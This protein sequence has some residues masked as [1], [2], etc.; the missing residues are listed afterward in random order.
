MEKSDIILEM[1]NSLEILLGSSLAIEKIN[2]LYNWTKGLINQEALI[3]ML[4][5]LKFQ[6]KNPWSFGRLF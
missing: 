2:R 1:K 6:A 4:F 3:S 5:W